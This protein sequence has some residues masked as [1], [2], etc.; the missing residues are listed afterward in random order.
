MA[1]SSNFRI[2]VADDSEFYQGLMREMLTEAGYE[3]HL[4]ADGLECLR[5]VRSDPHDLS[6]IILDIFMPELDGFGV[7]RELKRDKATAHIPVLAVSANYRKD[8]V[9]ELRRLGA[10]GYLNKNLPIEEILFRVNRI[11]YPNKDAIR[12]NPR[13]VDNFPVKYRIDDSLFTGYSFNISTGGVYIRT[14]YPPPENTPIR[15]SFDLPKGGRTIETVGTVVWRN[16]FRQDT[17]LALP[18]GFGVKFTDIPIEQ[19][20]AITDYILARLT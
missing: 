20:R 10:T 18:P 19:K 6:L 8:H 2:L 14:V 1:H 16:E 13:I 15:I 5:R 7:L 3:V 4:A 11:L 17:P 9:K 12:S